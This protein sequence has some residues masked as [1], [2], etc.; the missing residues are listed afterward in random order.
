[1]LDAFHS[2]IDVLLGKEFSEVFE[3]FFDALSI[4][5]RA[6]HA[7]VILHASAHWLIFGR[8][9]IWQLIVVV[10]LRMVVRGEPSRDP[11]HVLFELFA[12]VVSVDTAQV[13]I[14]SSS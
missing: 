2:L 13:P 8:M 9:D 5:L 14:G 11:K 12:A 7:C 10:H 1:M 3:P 4:L 6:P